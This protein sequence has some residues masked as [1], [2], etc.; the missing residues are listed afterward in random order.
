M[1]LVEIAGL[2]SESDRHSQYSAFYHRAD[3]RALHEKFLSI[4]RFLLPH[5]TEALCAACDNGELQVRCPEV[6][7]S[8]LL[9]GLIGLLGEGERPLSQRLEEAL[10]YAA[11]IL[12]AG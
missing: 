6:A 1:R 2:I 3:S 10:R 11:L 7:A 5:V 9:Y 8:Y 12:H 4:A